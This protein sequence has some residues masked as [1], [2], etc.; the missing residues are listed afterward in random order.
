MGG[1]NTGHLSSIKHSPAFYQRL[2]G[3]SAVSSLPIART[4]GRL[5]RAEFNAVMGRNHVV[6]LA[7]G[8]VVEVRA[9]IASDATRCVGATL[10]IGVARLICA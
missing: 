2:L 10:S 3:L 4:N 5:F 9:H 6:A 7:M 8:K 1:M